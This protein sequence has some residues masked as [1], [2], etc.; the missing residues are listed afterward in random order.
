MAITQNNAACPAILAALDS[1]TAAD[2]K[3]LIEPV[4]LVQ[5]LMDPLQPKNSAVQ[6]Y[7]EGG[8][9][10]PVRVYWTQRATEDEVRS[11]KSCDVGTLKVKQETNAVPDRYN[12]IAIEVSEEALRA[13][14]ATLAERVTLEGSSIKSI[15]GATDS[16][17]GLYRDATEEI[18]RALPA[19]RRK[20]NQNLITDF[21]ARV[22]KFQGQ[23]VS[24]SPSYTVRQALNNGFDGAPVFDGYA[25]LDQDLSSITDGARP[26]LFGRGIFDLANTALKYGCCNNGGTD[27][28]RM[29]DD[30]E[31][32]FNFYRDFQSG[33]I[34][35][36][37]V[38]GGFFPGMAQLL[39]YNEY[40]GPY[41]TPH[42]LTQRGTLSDPAI[43]GLKYDM[44][45]IPGS[46]MGEGWT[47]ILGLRYGLWVAPDQY[48]STDRLTGVN[49][50][51]KF[52]A[53]QMIA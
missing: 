36:A 5:A 14:C 39:R 10:Q 20:I 48:K 12:E 31:A 8:Q 28:G 23:G 37:N 17:L 38:V 50:T 47:I 3:K 6:R 41:A 25:K 2:P 11:A 18:I 26:I 9:V 43:P 15:A 40:V 7:G 21:L 51:L 24:P 35:G 30:S 27:F 19:L 44:R 45:V 33:A 32:Q 52:T 16:Q 22:G 34:L 53:A 13:L 46:C 29:R 42:G 4:G 49:G 1:V